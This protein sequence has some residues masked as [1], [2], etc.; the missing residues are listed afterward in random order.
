MKNQLTVDL[1]THLLSGA[2]FIPS[3][4]YDERPENMP[5]ELI[6]IHGIS[7]PP[8]RFG[9]EG[10]Q[11]LFTNRLDPEEDPYYQKIEGLRVSS[12]LFINRWGQVT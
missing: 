10:V 6:V 12:H 7:L 11:Q 4:N 2:R 9:G 1:N 3:P 5:V 8:G